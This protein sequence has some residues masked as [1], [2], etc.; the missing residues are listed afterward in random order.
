MASTTITGGG[1]LRI[2]DVL[3]RS[4]AVW[5]RIAMPCCVIYG[6]QV[7]PSA[8][9]DLFGGQH[10]VRGV[11]VSLMLFVVSVV[12]GLFGLLAAAMVVGAGNDVLHGRAADVRAGIALGMARFLPLLGAAFCTAIAVMLGFILLIVPGI[13]LAIMYSL[14]SP[15]VVLERQGP[16]ESM[17]RSAALTKGVRWRI[18]GLAL[19]VMVLALVAFGLTY[20]FRLALGHF[21]GEILYIVIFTMLGLFNT[22]LT[23]VVY[24]DLVDAREGFGAAG[25]VTA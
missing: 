22:T 4:Y 3:S 20:V 11:A 8:L 18:F 2:G 1:S 16:I 19:V 14:I 10:G 12:G 15:V 9:Q 17:K 24:R 13:I 25:F 7:V 5:S 6:L 23:L 21:A